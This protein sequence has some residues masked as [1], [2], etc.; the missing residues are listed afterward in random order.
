MATRVNGSARDEEEGETYHAYSQL[1]VP[2]PFLRVTRYSR[3]LNLGNASLTA[4]TAPKECSS[5]KG[6]ISI[7]VVAFYSLMGIGINRLPSKPIRAFRIGKTLER[8][9][10]GNT[11]N[12]FSKR[13]R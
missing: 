5:V 4:L 8:T 11:F 2:S 9:I 6:V 7:A 10:Q 3:P 13:N 12:V 1:L